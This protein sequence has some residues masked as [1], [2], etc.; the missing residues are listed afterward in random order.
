MAQQFVPPYGTA[1]KKPAP[2]Q[3][4]PIPMAGAPA[5]GE[6]EAEPEDGAMV[7]EQHGA[8]MQ[9]NT[10]HDDSMGVH[11]VHSVH[12]DGHEHH[13]DHASREEAHE[14]VGKLHGIGAKEHSEPDGDEGEEAEP[15]GK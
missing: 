7:H 6:G 1:G 12:E 14:H 5:M 2:A 15:W 3:K 9:V 11:H 4:K 13:S 10:E 8:P